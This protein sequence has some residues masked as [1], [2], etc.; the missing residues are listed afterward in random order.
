MVGHKRRCHKLDRYKKGSCAK[1]FREHEASPPSHRSALIVSR[2]EY[3]GQSWAQTAGVSRKLPAI[4]VRKANLSHK[5]V[6][7]TYVPK[8]S[9]SLLAIT[10][11]NN[12]VSSLLQDGAKRIP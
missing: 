1:G 5:K 7:G 12:R 6:E 11:C 8:V 2:Y 4:E 3:N 10:I 9:Q